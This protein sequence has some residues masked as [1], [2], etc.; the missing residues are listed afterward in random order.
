MLV[1]NAVFLI[2]GGASGLGAATARMAVERG[3][4]VV[5]CDVTE[6]AGNALASELGDAARFVRTD[7]TSEADASTALACAET[8][9]GGANVLVNCAGIIV[10]ERTSSARG[11]HALASFE[12]VIAVNLI[13]TF[14]MIRMA[15]S[16]MA[17]RG[18][19]AAGERGVI[20]NTASIAAFEGQVGQA[21][22]AASKGGVVSLTLAVA[23]DLAREGIR[24]M[25]IAPG[26]FETPMMEAAPDD[27]RIAL[28]EKIPF[29]SRFGRPDEYGALVCHIVENEFLN[30]EVIRLDGAVRM[31]PR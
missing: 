5:V 16:A 3:A 9:F 8:A 23:R 18:A 15:A 24:V 2:T 28:Q 26:P 7:V 21:A 12:R 22:Y 6:T 13:G 17:R 25:A 31:P 19:N 1:R 14:N 27:L 4:K 30:G 11:P 10:A 29:P 20:I